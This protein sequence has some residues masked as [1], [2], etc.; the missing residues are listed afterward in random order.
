MLN[1]VDKE[2]GKKLSYE[3]IRYNMATF[4][5]AG[6]ETTSATLAFSY[7]NLIKNPEKLHKAIQEVDDVLGDN[8][9]TVDMLPKL[10]YIDACTKETLRLSS[11]IAINNVTS[12]KDQVLG[13][14]TF[15][16]KDQ[17]VIVLL[18]YLHSDRKAWG[19]DVRVF[20]PERFLD[21]GFQKLKPH[22]CKTMS[23][24]TH[25]SLATLR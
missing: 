18:K 5:V 15:V 24:R 21:G 17:P 3:N 7:Y 14:N 10:H 22:S 25:R 9:L 12:A 16:A 20:M 13:E 2:T 6:H 1:D 8:V 23:F 11:P 19:D 4:L